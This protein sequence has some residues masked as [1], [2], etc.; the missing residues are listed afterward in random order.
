M[1]SKELRE[2]KN[3]ISV[4]PVLREK[5]E[6]LRSRIR[7][8]ERNA[9][10]LL[11]K[12]RKECLDVEQLKNNSFSAFLF[13][14]IGK[15]DGKLE[16]E[17]TEALTA[18]LRYDRACQF[19]DELRRELHET[20][21]RI[22][23]LKDQERI[24]DAEIKKREQMVLNKMDEEVYERYMKL[25]RERD[26][27]QKQLF[28]NDEA[29]NAAN[30]ARNTAGSVMS[31]LESADSWAT[32]DVWF[33]GGIISHMAKYDHIDR[34]EADVNRLYS[35]LRELKKELSDIS[36]NNVPGLTE[37]DS[38]TRFMDIWF[39]NLFTDLRV[40]NMIRDSMEQVENVYQN[41]GRI[42]SNVKDSKKEL[43]KRIEEIDRLKDELLLSL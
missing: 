8:A 39:D 10:E 24:Y 26:Y 14:V 27:V 37:F 9:E 25:E 13:K 29:I 11:D 23:A 2:I 30:R 6:K 33:K 41:L 42:I 34:A 31:H 7:E 19:A 22:M 36:L 43:Q 32:Y 1:D 4:L 21:M 3:N 12:Y 35:Q 28:E 16:K 40:R 17:E 5:A 18:K 20:E 15:Y 38:V